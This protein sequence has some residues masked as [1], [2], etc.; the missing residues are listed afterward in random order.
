MC[1]VG[2]CLTSSRNRMATAAYLRVSTGTQDLANQKLAILECWES[3][4][5]IAKR[6]RSAFSCKSRSQ[7]RPSPR[8]SASR[9]PPFTALSR[10]GGYA[11]ILKGYSYTN[12]VGTPIFHCLNAIWFLFW[13]L[14]FQEAL[15]LKPDFGPA[16]A[17]LD[18]VE[19]L[20]R[21]LEGHK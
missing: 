10:Q 9:G 17:D 19:A 11:H 6:K 1:K 15:R 21:Q 13:R 14:K 5:W 3:R 7:R 18:N 4:G 8:L 2:V 20:V 12:L 16:K